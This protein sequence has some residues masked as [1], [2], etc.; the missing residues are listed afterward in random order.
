M[1]EQAILWIFVIGAFSVFCIIPIIMQTWEDI[2]NKKKPIVTRVAKVLDKRMYQKEDSSIRYYY[3]TCEF[4]DGERGEFEVPE[5][6]YGVTIVGDR[7]IVL[8]QGT[9]SKVERVVGN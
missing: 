3:F 7:V 5:S 9:F 2:D 6:E 8:Q 4:E 1:G